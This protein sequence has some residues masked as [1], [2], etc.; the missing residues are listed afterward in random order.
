MQNIGAKCARKMLMKLTLI[1][2]FGIR[3]PKNVKIS[4]N[5]VKNTVL[6]LLRPKLTVFCIPQE[7][8]P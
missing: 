2:G 1:R 7:R 5:D 8:N 4:N 3:G 6:A